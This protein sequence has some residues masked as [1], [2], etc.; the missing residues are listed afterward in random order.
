[1]EQIF[2]LPT[3]L[4]GFAKKYNVLLAAQ[5]CHFEDK[6]AFTGDVSPLLLQKLAIENVILGHSERREYY[7]EKNELIA[8]KFLAAQKNNLMPIICVGEKKQ[9][10]EEGKEKEVIR[11]QLFKSLPK[12]NITNSFLIA[13]EPVWAI[14]TGL[15]A[16]YKQIENMFNFIKELIDENG[17]L[18]KHNKGILYGGSV[19]AKNSDEISKVANLSGYLV[20][21]AS[22]KKDEWQKIIN[23]LQ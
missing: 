1:M 17:N 5:D 14:G 23:S 19:N 20:G 8:K 10:R 15:V 11:K 13:Y 2:S 18:K 4:L 3:A 21:S 22:L 16:S 9:E 12:E 7:F 6:G